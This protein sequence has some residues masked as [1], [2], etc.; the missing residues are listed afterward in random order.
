[1]YE[2]YLRNTKYKYTYKTCMKKKLYAIHYYRID[3]IQ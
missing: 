3:L 2:N 1:M